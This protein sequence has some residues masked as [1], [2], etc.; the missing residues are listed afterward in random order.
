MAEGTKDPRVRLLVETI[1][2]LEELRQ[3]AKDTARDYRERIEVIES[4]V[5][6]LAKE[7]RTG[8]ATLFDERRSAD[9]AAT[10]AEASAAVA[11]RKGG[12]LESVTIE[13]AGESVTLT[14]AD[15]ERM[16]A[17]ARAMRA[18]AR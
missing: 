12:H 16:R 14:A 15:G 4:E 3:E 9:A 2:R 7:S 10:L 5:S 13:H 1:E 11:P 17:T 6:V 8:Q 18:R